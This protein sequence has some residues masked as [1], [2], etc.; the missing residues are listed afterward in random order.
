MQRKN[1]IILGILVFFL[2]YLVLLMLWLQIKPY[3]GWML[4]QTGSRLA[5]MTAGLRLERVQQEKEVAAVTFARTVVTGKGLGDLQIELKISVSSYS[6]NVPLTFALVAGLFCLFKWRKR[7]LVEAGLILL[8]VHLLYIYSYCCLELFKYLTQSGMR[9]TSNA[10]Q[11]F[12]QFM[13]AFT[14]NMII[15]FEPFLVAVYL[16][17]RNYSGLRGAE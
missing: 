16:W 4:T 9:T 10:L 2:S 6:F 1:R 15:R 14:D 8:T 5:A 7:S 11:F 12:L 17:L 13:W 3:Y